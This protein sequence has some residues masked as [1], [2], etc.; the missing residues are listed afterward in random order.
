MFLICFG[1][2]FFCFYNLFFPITHA[3]PKFSLSY[4]LLLSGKTKC[5]REP[6]AYLY[7]VLSFLTIKEYSISQSS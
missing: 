3:S 7:P 4:I 2:F 5:G 1:F 6:S